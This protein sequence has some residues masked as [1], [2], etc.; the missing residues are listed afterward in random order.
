VSS[1]LSFEKTDQTA[2][3]CATNDTADNHQQKVKG[4]RQV[5]GKANVT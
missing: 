3:D 1:G 4:K 2:P 5:V